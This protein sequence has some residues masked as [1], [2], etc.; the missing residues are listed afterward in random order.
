VMVGAV[1]TGVAPWYCRINYALRTARKPSWTDP[2]TGSVYKLETLDDRKAALQVAW[3]SGARKTGNVQSQYVQLLETALETAPIPER[4]MMNWDQVRAVHK[5]GHIIGGHTL[6]HP[7]LAHV[8]DTEAK[9]EIEG[10]KL[11][12][13]K[14]LS[15]SVEHFSYPHPALNPQCNDRTVAI[16]RAAGYKSSVLTSRGPI[17]KGDEPLRLK[18]IYAANDLDQFIWNLEVTFLGR[19][20]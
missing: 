19:A 6:S 12:L 17:R 14:E 9:S 5:A 2:E 13:E 3:N 1:E 18:R 16:T 10:C 15:S 8:S 20:V 4:L 7:N 11:R